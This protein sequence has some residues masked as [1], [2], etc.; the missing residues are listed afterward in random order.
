MITYAIIILTCLVS[1]PAFNN[2]KLFAKALFNPYLVKT[3]KQWYRFFSHALV[4]ADW[5]HLFFNMFV[6]YSF[7]TILEDH[8]FPFIFPGFKST[9]NYILLYVGALIAS[10][11]PG[12]EKYKNQPHYNAV[13]ASG[14]VAAVVFAGILINPMQ[15]IG[16]IFIPFPIPGFIFGGLYLLYSWYMAKK[17]NDNIGH[18]AHFWGA[19]FGFAFTGLLKPI[20]FL[21]F[22]DQLKS[23]FS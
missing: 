13:G 3:N 14:A 5:M 7:G 8:L 23:Y 20:L 9:L 11:I 1:I 6:L 21:N 10:S 12:F 2:R 15:G 16:F 22:I 19:V 4:H 17:G 18:D